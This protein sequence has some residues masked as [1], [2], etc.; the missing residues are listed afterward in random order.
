MNLLEQYIELF[1]NLS[2]NEVYDTMLEVGAAVE[3]EVQRTPSS[4]VH[5]CQSQVWIN[6]NDL[7]TGW[8]FRL[9]S[10]SYMVK[11]VGSIICACLSGLTSEELDNIGFYDFKDLAKHFSQQRKQGMQAIIN[12]CKHISKGNH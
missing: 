11:G 8:E 4:V 3:Y 5:G 7:P 6:G 1:D 9:D 10:D 2:S 12:K